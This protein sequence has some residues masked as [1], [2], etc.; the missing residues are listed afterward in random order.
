MFVD[1]FFKRKLK[2]TSKIQY[3]GRLEI[4]DSTLKGLEENEKTDVIEAI[5]SMSLMTNNI[6]WT[7]VSEDD[8]EEKSKHDYTLN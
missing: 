1:I 5:I 8:L 6:E 3:L 7:P 2:D 4:F